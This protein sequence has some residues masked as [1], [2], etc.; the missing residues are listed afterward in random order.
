MFALSLKFYEKTCKAKFF[1]GV[2]GVYLYMF[3]C[4]STAFMGLICFNFCFKDEKS[5]FMG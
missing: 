5:Y 2:A 1:V 4:D 3:L